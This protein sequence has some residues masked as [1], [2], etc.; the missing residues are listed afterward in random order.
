[1]RSY[2]GALSTS[3]ADD[4]STVATCAKL[5]YLLA[6]AALKAV[7]QLPHDSEHAARDCVAAL[8]PAVEP[9]AEAPL[10]KLLNV[11]LGGLEEGRPHSV[12]ALELLPVLLALLLAKATPQG[13]LHASLPLLLI[14]V[15]DAAASFT[16]LR[17]LYFILGVNVANPLLAALQM[18]PTA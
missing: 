18:T 9:L 12:P 13:A 2:F 16:Q 8:K 1:M 10:V 7:Y 5:R 6:S 3:A 17:I 14:C 15:V 4:A 11:V